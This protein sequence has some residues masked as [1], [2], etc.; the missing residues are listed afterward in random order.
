MGWFKSAEEK[1]AEKRKEELIEKYGEKDGL[2]IYENKISEEKYLE[3]KEKEKK[4]AAQ[5][6]VLDWFD[7]KN[8]SIT[9]SNLFSEDNPNKR[10]Y[11][12]AKKVED[13][14]EYPMNAMKFI[15]LVK[16]LIEEGQLFTYDDDEYI[17]LLVE[18]YLIKLCNCY[19]YL[20]S[21]LF[22]ILP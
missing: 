6:K 15:Q 20:S 2:R 18:L 1:A 14:S 22:N 11:D 17:L 3:E 9:L 13:T 21:I 7:K 4:K 10:D 16:E 8:G 12:I 5:Q 19:K